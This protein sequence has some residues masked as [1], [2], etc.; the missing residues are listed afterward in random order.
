MQMRGGVAV[1]SGGASGLGEAVVRRLAGD[2]AQVVI[3]DLA[4]ERAEAL[5][6]ELG[7]AVSARPCDVTE[8]DQVEA[9]IAHATSLG[10]LRAVVS[11]A[12]IAIAARVLDK[13][14]VPHDAAAFA[15]VMQINLMGS[16]HLA[17]LGAA[18]MVAHTPLVRDQ[19][20]AIVLTASIAA[21]DGQMGQAAYAA[22]KGGI[23]AMTLPLAR[24]LAPHGIRVCTVC[25]GIMDTP[26]LAGLPEPA[27]AALAASIPLPR[28]LGAPAE[29][30]ALVAHVIDNDYLNGECIRIDGGLRMGLR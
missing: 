21:Y 17:R 1:V 19:R 8:A 13:Q 28:R 11:C 3:A 16:F 10:P 18:A 27:R 30:A 15:R 6:A 24:D 5:A 12:G 14:G 23:V 26:L 22:S 2:G 25:P 4:A 7:P 20:G 9:A 29:F